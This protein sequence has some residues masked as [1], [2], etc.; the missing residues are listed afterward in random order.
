MADRVFL[1]SFGI[2]VRT[3]IGSIVLRLFK[4]FMLYSVSSFVVGYIRNEFS[5]G[6]LSVS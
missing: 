1:N 2:S 4:S 6:V 3:L 5:F